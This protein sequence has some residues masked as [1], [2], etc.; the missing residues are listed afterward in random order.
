MQFTYIISFDPCNSYL[1]KTQSY[2]HFMGKKWL[3]EVKYLDV[4]YSYH[5]LNLGSIT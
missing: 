1:K 3:R 4:Q 5:G 2:P